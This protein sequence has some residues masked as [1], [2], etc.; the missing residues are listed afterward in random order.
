MW[1]KA[2]HADE[3]ED[4]LKQALHIRQETY[5]DVPLHPDRRNAA[6][7]LI[8]CLLVRAAAGENRG[9]REMQARQLADQYGVDLDE[10]VAIA[11]QI[12]YDPKAQ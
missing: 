5:H 12:P 3:A 10:R 11:A 1:L 9:H 6:G 8:S 2:G 7:W 4:L